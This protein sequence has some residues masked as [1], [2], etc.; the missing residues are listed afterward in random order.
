MKNNKLIVYKESIFSKISN[1]FKKIFNIARKDENKVAFSNVNYSLQ[2]DEFI[3]NIAIK[4]NEEENRLK[5]LQLKYENGEISE[6]EI[7]EEDIDN[8]IEM[9]KKETEKLN[10]D[11][12]RRKNHIS[13]MLN[14]L[15]AS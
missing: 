3:S 6:A 14:E 13:K 8:L 15:K 4:E 7:P 12:E 9:Y 5:Q 1:F 11:T 2:K 10:M